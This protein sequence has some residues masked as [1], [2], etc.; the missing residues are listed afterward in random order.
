[1]GAAVDKLIERIYRLE[2]NL[3]E[4][5]ELKE[6]KEVHLYRKYE[7]MFLSNKELIEEWK[8]LVK[9]KIPLSN[10]HQNKVPQKL[11]SEGYIRNDGVGAFDVFFNAD[12]TRLNNKNMAG[13]GR[14]WGDCGQ[15]EAVYFDVR[16]L[17]GDEIIWNTKEEESAGPRRNRQ[18]SSAN[19][20]VLRATCLKVIMDYYE[21]YKNSLISYYNEC[22]D[23]EEK[24]YIQE[25]EKLNKI[26]E[27]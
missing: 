23:K 21:E 8:K 19:T 26:L 6:N 11:S 24:K 7:K 1:M 22:L 25:V 4:L 17:G 27:G 16:N 15:M 5:E 2:K 14:S 18:F 10:F 12:Y 9:V 13:F 20:L 3:T